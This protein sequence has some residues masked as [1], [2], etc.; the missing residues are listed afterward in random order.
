MYFITLQFQK[1]EQD[2]KSKGQG[3][4]YSLEEQVQLRGGELGSE[5]KKDE[6][7]TK[8]V[9]NKRK[10]EGRCMKC[11]RSNYQA[12]DYKA[13]LRA[14]TLPFP[15]DVKKEPVQ[16]KRKFDKGHLKIT[17]LGLEEDLENE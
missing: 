15:D 7:V 12:Q 11:R 5:K 10:I 13:P 1:K 16:K 4:K 17:K 8:E 3:K 14:K 6:F 2:N 9:W